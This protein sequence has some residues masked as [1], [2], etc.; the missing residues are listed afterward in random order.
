[1][2]SISTRYNGL[3]PTKSTHSRL[4]VSNSE[5]FFNQKSVPLSHHLR[6]SVTTNLIYSSLYSLLGNIKF[7][8]WNWLY[9]RFQLVSTHKNLI[10][11][12]KKNC[13]TRFHNFWKEER[14]SSYILKGNIYIYSFSIS[15]Y[16]YRCTIPWSF[17]IKLSY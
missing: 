11:H 3:A 13:G 1:M 7:K 5:M 14:L 16:F 15:K 4:S 6:L 17:C 12:I 2:L 9:D 10:F 8:C